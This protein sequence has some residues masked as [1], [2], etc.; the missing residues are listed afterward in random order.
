[1]TQEQKEQA[2]IL[3]EYVLNNEAWH[4]TKEKEAALITAIRILRG[5]G[6]VRTSERFPTK[7]DSPTGMVVNA[8]SY[9]SMNGEYG[10][11]VTP[12]ED[13]KAIANTK[14]YWMPLPPIPEADE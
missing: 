5:Q 10:F 9:S 4:L 8:W 2:A 6:W 14:D 13:V 12:Y 7:Q 1:M 3:V 11:M